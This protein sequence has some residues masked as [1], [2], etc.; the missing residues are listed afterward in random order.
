MAE[1][2]IT[3][4]KCGAEM[5]V[6][7]SLAAPL[8]AAT[9]RE[10]EGKIALKDSHVAKREAAIREKEAALKQA[11]DSI[12]EKVAAK[13]ESQKA[14]I[15]TEE[16]RKAKLLVPN[17]LKQKADEINNLQTVTKELDAKLAEAQ[18]AQAELIRKQ[19]EFG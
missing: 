1:P 2:T 13:L 12:D 9:R 5:K 7:E 3:C 18:K 16:A 14:A 11:H 8:I 15:S 17:E 6:T 10:F 4:P 19:R